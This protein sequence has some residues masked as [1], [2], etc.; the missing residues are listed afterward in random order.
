MSVVAAKPKLW[1]EVEGQG[2][3]EI[4]LFQSNWSLNQIPTATAVVAVG[5]R[6][7]SGI[8]A[9]RI[10]GKLN[11]IRRS[12]AVKVF[13]EVAGAWDPYTDW[14]DGTYVV[15]DGYIL[16][17]GYQKVNGKIQLVVHMI[18]WLADLHYSSTLSGQSHPSNP[19]DL[20]FNAVTR[21]LGSATA[22][23]GEGLYGI[24]MTAEAETITPIALRE[25]LWGAAIKPMLCALAQT[26]HVQLSVDL[27]SQCHILGTGA[28]TSALNALSRIEGEGLT[29][30]DCDLENS[31]YAP[32]LSME[33]S[34]SDIPLEIAN[35][36]AVAIRKGQI[37]SFAHNTFWGKMLQYSAQF[38]FAIVPLV[39]SAIVVPFVP[40]LRT[41][42]CKSILADE[43]IR[44]NIG[45]ESQRPV[46][47]VALAGAR[48]S[49]T[50][51]IGGGPGML[52]VLG[53]YA[54]E[55]AG[56]DDGMVLVRQAPSWLVGTSYSGYS[57]GRTT[58]L[59]GTRAISSATT[60]KGTASSDIK[61]SKDGT[62]PETTRT[63]ARDVGN[64]YA[65]YVYVLE[66]LRNRMGYV[67]GRL[68]F[69]IAP[70]SNVV[71]EGTTERFLPSSEVGQ[72]MIGTVVRVTV[73]IDAETPGASTSFQ[74]HHCR[75]ED[76]NEDD[77]TSLDLHPLYRTMFT[78][79]PLIPDLQ[80]PND[81]CC[82]D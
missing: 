29:E 59:S 61:G 19:T 38:N 64:G 67:G 63:S 8:T 28:N 71:V 3:F 12:V 35:S 55:D 31:C 15:F 68:R 53:C 65:H 25:D 52:G 51:F 82:E 66:A 40:G 47:G 74:L 54:P 70:G 4:S 62:L 26:E 50:N 44:V 34:D 30:S 37:E 72:S 6:A 11:A 41:P 57:L 79:A 56:V 24:G 58:G 39:E 49:A 1:L 78:G 2:R 17:P 7:P 9:A 43:H 33:W 36:I 23:S 76:E 21:S 18:H 69:D 20:T 5:R 81:D 22:F 45:G 42:Y 14:P 27:S 48:E 80:F 77:L 13:M 10:H 60:P 75:T 32:K 16:G 73:N 46:R